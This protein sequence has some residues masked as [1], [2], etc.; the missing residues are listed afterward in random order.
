MQIAPASADVIG[1]E[2]FEVTVTGIATA[3]VAPEAEPRKTIA[4][5]L[6]ESAAPGNDV[7]DSGVVFDVTSLK[8]GEDGVTWNV[9]ARGQQARKVSPPA[10]ALMLAGKPVS[11]VERALEKDRLRLSRLDWR[12]AW[13]PLM[14][15]LDARI[16]VVVER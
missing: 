6:R 3:Y 13:W 5:K 1:K 12:P 4:A 14:P 10:T 2:S 11:E 8:V 15:L 9:T 16:T 7:D